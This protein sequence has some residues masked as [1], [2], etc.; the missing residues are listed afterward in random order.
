MDR[1]DLSELRNRSELCT[2]DGASSL[3]GDCAGSVDET[4]LATAEPDG[5]CSMQDEPNGVAIRTNQ[6]PWPCSM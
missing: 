6:S 1:N 2:A 4:L 5:L 3:S